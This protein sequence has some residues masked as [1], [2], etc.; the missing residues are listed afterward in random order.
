MLAK[1][2]DNLAPKGQHNFKAVT[3]LN[4]LPK[5]TSMVILLSLQKQMIAERLKK[6][7]KPDTSSSSDELVTES[8]W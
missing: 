6:R 2:K 7:N 3:G 5:T 8:F 1:I 4:Q